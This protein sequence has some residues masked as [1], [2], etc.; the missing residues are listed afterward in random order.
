MKS[1]LEKNGIEMDSTDNEGESVVA[2]RLI[3][4][5][6]IKIYKCMINNVYIDKLDDIVNKYDNTHHRKLK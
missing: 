4:T 6:K 3:K 1:W 2:Q 5:I